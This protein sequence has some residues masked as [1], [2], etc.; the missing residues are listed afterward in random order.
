MNIIKISNIMGVDSKPFDPK[1]YVEEDTFV[2]DESGSKKR[3]R[4]ENNIVRWRTV[5]NRDGTSSVSRNFFSSYLKTC[6]C[7]DLSRCM[8]SAS[9]HASAVVTIIFFSLLSVSS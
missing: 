5:K 9:L 2:T 8:Y 3:I 4:L 1:T 6:E 7:M